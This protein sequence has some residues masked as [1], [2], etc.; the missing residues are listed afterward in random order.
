MRDKV[1][2]KMILTRSR[3]IPMRRRAGHRD[4]RPTDP[5]VYSE[6]LYYEFLAPRNFPVTIITSCAFQNEAGQTIV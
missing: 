1:F 3:R 2:Q 4:A 6:H 5:T